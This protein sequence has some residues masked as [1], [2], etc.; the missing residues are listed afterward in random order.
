MF[1]RLHYHK[2]RGMQRANEQIVQGKILF[3]LQ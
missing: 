3:R 2:W 1:V